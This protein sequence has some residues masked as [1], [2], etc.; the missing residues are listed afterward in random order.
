[1]A[2]NVIGQATGGEK[3]VFDNVSTVSEIREK[4]SLASNYIA[5]VNGEPADDDYELEDGDF[6]TLSE[7]VKGQSL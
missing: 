4:M 5:S 7:K 3:K 1:M 6:V 2:Q